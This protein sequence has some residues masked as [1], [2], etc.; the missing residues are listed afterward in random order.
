MEDGA[1]RDKV[2]V[3]KIKS[4]DVHIMFLFFLDFDRHLYMNFAYK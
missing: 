3:S 2:Q 4:I 1:F